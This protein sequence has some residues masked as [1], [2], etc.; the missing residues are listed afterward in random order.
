MYKKYQDLLIRG[1]RVL[2]LAASPPSPQGPVIQPAQQSVRRRVCTRNRFSVP[3]TAV[4][5]RERTNGPWIETRNNGLHRYHTRYENR[6]LPYLI[7]YLPI[8][9]VGDLIGVVLFRSQNFRSHRQRIHEVCATLYPHGRAVEV[10]QE[11]FSIAVRTVDRGGGDGGGG[12]KTSLLTDYHGR[13]P[14]WGLQCATVVHKKIFCKN[15]TH[16]HVP[17]IPKY[18][19]SMPGTRSHTPPAYV[20]TSHATYG[21]YRR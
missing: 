19:Q 11:P 1:G 21:S 12:E 4:R 20:L 13:L 17:T 6:T 15:K 16:A 14:F 5:C 18:S 7:K 9:E 10:H 2:I 8:P 3:F